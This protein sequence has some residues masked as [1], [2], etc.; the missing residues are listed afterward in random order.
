MAEV[1]APSLNQTS[2]NAFLNT[3]A[4]MSEIT[5]RNQLKTK[6]HGERVNE[7]QAQVN[8]RSKLVQAALKS[9]DAALKTAIDKNQ[10]NAEL[11]IAIKAAT[12][13]LGKVLKG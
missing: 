8:E 9:A 11:A 4:R 1:V 3:H 12:L 5:A 10:N 13:L 6:Q 2:A 7:A